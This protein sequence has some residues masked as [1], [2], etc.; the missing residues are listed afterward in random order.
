MDLEPYLRENERA[1]QLQLSHALV[2]HRLL[3]PIEHQQLGKELR[4]LSAP[5]ELGDDSMLQKRGILVRHQIRSR[6]D[7]LASSSSN[8]PI[9]TGS[10]FQ[11]TVSMLHSDFARLLHCITHKGTESVESKQSAY[12]DI[13]SL[14][15]RLQKLVLDH[16]SFFDGELRDR[17]TRSSRIEALK[18]KRDRLTNAVEKAQKE[19]DNQVAKDAERAETELLRSQSATLGRMVNRL[20]EAMPLLKDAWSQLYGPE[21]AELFLHTIQ[22]F[23]NDC[24]NSTD[25]VE[26]T[27]IEEDCHFL[28]YFFQTGLVR[29]QPKRF[30]KLKLNFDP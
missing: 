20:V 26:I 11:T 1:T 5:S 17:E 13:K 19:L 7:S 22:A 23:M 21:E 3:I 16:A 8:S 10:S 14:E 18:K 28:S 9:P 12:N 2:R 27:Q 15:I 25:G 29:S 6:L 30:G 4:A 24:L